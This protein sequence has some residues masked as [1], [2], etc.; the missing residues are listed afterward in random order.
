MR[1]LACTLFFAHLCYSYGSSNGVLTLINSEGAVRSPAQVQALVGESF[2]QPIIS[3][4]DASAGTGVRLINSICRTDVKVESL[5]CITLTVDGRRLLL[6]STYQ[7]M[8]GPK[9]SGS[10]AAE[11]CCAVSDAVVVLLSAN[12]L[13]E[14][15]HAHEQVLRRIAARISSGADSLKSVM[16]LVDTSAKPGAVLEKLSSDIQNKFSDIYVDTTGKVN[17]QIIKK[18]EG[19]SFICA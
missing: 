12:E 15:L 18:S 17:Y 1:V 16:F 4:I 10:K 6:Y 3:V 9:F 13:D 11:Y 8:Y 7:Q 14:A 2:V 5:N 19:R